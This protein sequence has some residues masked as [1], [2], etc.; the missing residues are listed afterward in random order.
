MVRRKCK[1]CGKIEMLNN[2]TKSKYCRD[3]QYYISCKKINNLNK[4][5]KNSKTMKSM[6]ELMRSKSIVSDSQANN[7]I[8]N[9]NKW[10]DG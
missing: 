7:L 2:N 9:I 5:F 8:I 4:E 1:R 3:C 10:I 6:V